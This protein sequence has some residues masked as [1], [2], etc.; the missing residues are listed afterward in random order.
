MQI[1]TIQKLARTCATMCVTYS[2][3]YTVIIII[4][5][6]SSH[7]T[8]I[9]FDL[10]VAIYMFIGSRGAFFYAGGA[11]HGVLEVTCVKVAEARRRL[12]CD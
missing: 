1:H 4:I 10:F 11:A 2:I 7:H 8:I 3:I 5:I 9:R 6:T 12:S